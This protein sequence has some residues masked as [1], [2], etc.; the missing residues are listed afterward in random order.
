MNLTKTNCLLSFI[1]VTYIICASK[2]ID[3]RDSIFYSQFY[4]L[5]LLI[6]VLMV[7]PYHQRAGIALLIIALITHLPV[8]KEKFTNLITTPPP[9]RIEN[10]ESNYEISKN[11]RLVDLEKIKEKK[12]KREHRLKR[13]LEQGHISPLEKDTIK[14]IEKKFEKDLDYL[15]SDN[16]YLHQYTDEGNPTDVGLLPKTINLEKSGLDYQSLVKEGHVIQF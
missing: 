7:Y 4:K 10:R 16:P 2:Y 15:K 5:V 6:G 1:I 14:E 3:H 8:F 11:K 12:R 13:L 9:D